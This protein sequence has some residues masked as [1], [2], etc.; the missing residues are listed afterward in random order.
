MR[1]LRKKER[2][3]RAAKGTGYLAMVWKPL[4]ACDLA[5]GINA[6]MLVTVPSGIA[7]SKCTATCS[8]ASAGAISATS[9]EEGPSLLDIQP[10]AVADGKAAAQ[11]LISATFS[12]YFIEDIFQGLI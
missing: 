10:P 4:H 6:V 2:Q 9:A 11:D 12:E 8:S 7:N 3:S 5:G 1:H